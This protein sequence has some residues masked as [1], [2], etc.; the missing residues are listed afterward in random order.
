MIATIVFLWLFA[1]F[2]TLAAWHSTVK[3]NKQ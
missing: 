3:H 1:A 2:V